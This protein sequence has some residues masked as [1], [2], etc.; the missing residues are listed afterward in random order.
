MEF[1]NILKRIKVTKHPLQVMCIICNKEIMGD[2]EKQVLYRLKFHQ[3]QS[4]ECK[5]IRSKKTG[6]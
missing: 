6:K 2:T 4:K 1:K 5:R 3:N